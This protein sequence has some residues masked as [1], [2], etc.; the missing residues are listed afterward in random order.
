MWTLTHHECY[1]CY[2]FT[3]W[4]LQHSSSAL[5][6]CWCQHFRVR[7]WSAP[8]LVLAEGASSP[9]PVPFPWSLWF[10]CW[11]GGDLHC[12]VTC[13][14]VC[15]VFAMDTLSTLQRSMSGSSFL[16]LH[17][18]FTMTVDSTLF[19]IFAFQSALIISISCLV[20]DHFFSWILV[21]FHL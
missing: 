19:P 6:Y 5:L 13:S 10:P 9:P 15:S 1:L 11:S 3:L 16:T 21:K 17:P 2:I 4:F 14:V 20:C 7:L 8:G 12:T 18:N